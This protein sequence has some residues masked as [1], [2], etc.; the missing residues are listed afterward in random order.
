MQKHESGQGILLD[1]KSSAS[2]RIKE[3]AQT[4]RYR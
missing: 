3:R 2:Q 4:A 1:E